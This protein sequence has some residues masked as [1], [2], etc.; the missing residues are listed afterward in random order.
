[1]SSEIIYR[2][3]DREALDKEYNARDSVPD[4]T[5]YIKQYAELSEKARRALPCRLDLAYGPHPAMTLDFFSAGK[6]TPLFIYI[7]GGYW[8]ALSSRD[9]AFLAEN[10]V[11]HGI[12]VAA[13][14][15]ALVPD[16][17]LDEIVRQCRAAVAWCAN[18]AD[19]LEI[20]KTRIFAGGSSAGGHLAGMIAADGWQQSF[21]VPRDIVKGILSTSGLLDLEPIRLCHVNDWMQLDHETAHRNSPLHH[22]PAKHCRVITGAGGSES[23]EFKRQSA[24]YAEKCRKSGLSVIEVEPPGRNHF[25]VIMELC[26]AESPLTRELLDMVFSMTN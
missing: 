13:L 22:L 25:D 16:V 23:S 6:N 14:N 15:Y 20:D 11:A 2:G 12:S 17:S 1:M 3:F 4:F 21:S 5:V 9:S 8:R 24:I 19:N 7:H 10:L 26:N 18:E